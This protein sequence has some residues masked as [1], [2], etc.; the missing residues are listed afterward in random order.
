M[1]DATAHDEELRALMGLVLTRGVGPKL[2]RLLYDH[3]GCFSDV[4][5]L[6]GSSFRD[7]GFSRNVADAL[8]AGFP[9]EAV[10]AELARVFKAGA[11][12]VP[13]Y[14]G[15]YPRLLSGIT[16]PPVVLYVKGTLTELDL[17]SVAIVG[18]RKCTS[19]GKKH[20]ERLGVE[21]AQAGFTVVSGMAYGIDASA[22]RG[23]LKAGGRT[24]AVLGSGLGRIY[25]EDHLELAVEIA[26]QGAVIS[27]FPMERAPEAGNFP[28]RNRLMSGLSL[29]VV[30]VEATLR[31]G[32]L[33]TANLAL[34]Q[35]REVFAMPGP[36]D[37]PY[38]QG[39][40][41]LLREG[42]GLVEKAED[43][44]N[45]LGP[46]PSPVSLDPPTPRRRTPAGHSGPSETPAAP[47]RTIKDAREV[48]LNDRER[49]VFEQL[50][51]TEPRSVD[52]IVDATG[53][54]VS[55]VTGTLLSLEL[56]SIVQQLPGKLY[57]VK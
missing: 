40:H 38:S 46:L 44:V 28:Q 14:S 57:L 35:G 1:F 13:F 21:L 29:G 20:A 4:W 9:E 42:A 3:A 10:E 55:M 18:A 15:K 33:I 17:M 32:S 6:G 27:E 2:C 45:A 56:K 8:S 50:T 49:S 47:G 31:S 22:H 5:G 16:D 25:P 7:M 11:D 26:E 48:L 54:P 12:L 30:V 19:Y 23:A 34:E 36:V 52:D 51:S 43:V 41:K 53:L 37:S 39:C 24:L